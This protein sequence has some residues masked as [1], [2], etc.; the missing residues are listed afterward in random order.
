HEAA[1]P[2]NGLAGRAKLQGTGNPLP[3]ARKLR[4]SEH[5]ELLKFLRS[6]PPSMHVSDHI[7]YDDAA[8]TAARASDDSSHPVPPAG[9]GA[10][11][12]VTDVIGATAVLHGPAGYVLSKCETPCSFNNLKPQ[13]YSLEVQKEGYQPVQTA[14]QIKEGEAQDQKIKLESLAKGIFI[15]TQPP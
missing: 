11:Q 13:R 5:G 15:A 12:V 14:L 1:L 9:R 4:P 8:T 6:A 7:E 2:G 10:I 3:L